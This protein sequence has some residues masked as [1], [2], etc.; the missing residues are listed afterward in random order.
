MPLPGFYFRVVNEKEHRVG[1]LIPINELPATADLNAN[2]GL[3][4]L[5]VEVLEWIKRRDRFMPVIDSDNGSRLVGPLDD[6]FDSLER[7]D[8][9]AIEILEEIALSF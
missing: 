9:R 5:R 1:R 7:L 3:I 8:P 2:Q 6:W 4:L